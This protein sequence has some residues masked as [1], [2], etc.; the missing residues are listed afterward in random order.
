MIFTPRT[1][2]DKRIA[3]RLGDVEQ[4]RVHD[5]SASKADLSQRELLAEQFKRAS[6]K[7]RQENLHVCREFEALEADTTAR[8]TQTVFQQG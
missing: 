6:Q 7:C 5:L 1:V 8:K 3:E 4:R 2:A